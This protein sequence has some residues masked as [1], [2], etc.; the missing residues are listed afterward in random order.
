[1]EHAGR[2]DQDEQSLARRE[3]APEQ[4]EEFASSGRAHRQVSFHKKSLRL[5]AQ[6]DA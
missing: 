1:M 4:R 6:S 3:V 5:P 2:F